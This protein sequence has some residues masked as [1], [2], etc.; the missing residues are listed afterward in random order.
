MPFISD[1]CSLFYYT[2]FEMEEFYFIFLGWTVLIIKCVKYLLINV[3][4]S[5]YGIKFGYK[6]CGPIDG[7]FGPQ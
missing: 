5:Y 7:L 4:I 2:F 6:E 1:S 3:V